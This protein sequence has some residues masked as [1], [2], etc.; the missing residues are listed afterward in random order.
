MQTRLGRG[1]RG[2]L[3]IFAA[4]ALVGCAGLSGPA[5]PLVP[6]GEVPSDNYDVGALVSV[7]PTKQ[8]D[9]EVYA[10]ILYL[11][12]ASTA[13]QIWEG[14]YPAGSR[15]WL[16][17]QPLGKGDGKEHLRLVKSADHYDVMM[18]PDRDGRPLGYALV[19]KAVRPASLHDWNGKVVLFLQASN[20]I[21]PN[22]IG[23]HGNGR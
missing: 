15:G 2:T 17:L 12:P 20:F 1:L 6:A 4:A 3:A 14:S 9:G 19:H 22:Y 8:A 13:V 16:V 5:R 10:A 18:L 23:S 21:D 7:A 11:L